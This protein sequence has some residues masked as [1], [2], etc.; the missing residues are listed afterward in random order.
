LRMKKQREVM[1]FEIEAVREAA[2][3]QFEGVE[4][5]SG[6]AMRVK[7]KRARAKKRVIRLRQRIKFGRSFSRLTGQRCE[8]KRL[9]C[10]AAYRLA[11]WLVP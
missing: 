1:L 2:S 11:D 7:R 8:S 5:K 3:V 10:K 6:R 4:A 9:F